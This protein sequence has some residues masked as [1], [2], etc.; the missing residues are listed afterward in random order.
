MLVSVAIAMGFSYPSIALQE[1]ASSGLSALAHQVWT[2]AKPIE[3]G[4]LAVDV[5][6]RQVW[7]HGSYMK[8]LEKDVLKQ[9]LRI[10]RS[11]VHDDFL[12]PLN[13]GYH[14]PLMYWNS[15]EQSIDDDQ[16]IL[17]TINERRHAMSSLDVVL[18]PATVLA[19]KKFDKDE[20]VGADALVITLMNKLGDEAGAEWQVELKMLRESVCEHCIIYPD[21]GEITNDK[22]YE[23]SLT[24][25]SLREHSALALAY[26]FMAL[27]VLLSLRRM[28]AFHSRF[29][30]V[31]TAITQMTCSILAS[32]TICDILKINLST[33]PQ[34]AYPFVVL[35]FGVENMFRLI[36]AVLAY[37]PT[38][39]TEMRIAQALGD[40]G[41]ISVAAAAQNLTILSILSTV[42][43][44]GVAAFCAFA[45]I[46][47]LFDAFFL[48]TFFVAVLNVDIHRLE[49]QDALAA[50][51][52]QSRP[53]HRR[54]PSPTS[55]TWF[56]A[57][58]HGRLP[59]S[60][61]MAGTIVT[62]TFILSL[63]YHFSEHHEQG[64][65]LRQ[66]LGLERGAS[67]GVSDV[68]PFAAPLMN[69]TSSPADW[70][71][72]QDLDTARELIKLAKP[73][74]SSL[75]VRV[76]A[77][78]MIVLDG[79][80]RSGASTVDEPWTHAL[81]SFAIHYFYPV[82]VAVVF[83]VA[84]VFVLM[85]FLL[86]S[87]A[88][89]EDNYVALEHLEDHFTVTNVALPHSLDVVKMRSCE[90]GHFVTIGLDRTIAITV[91]DRAQ[92]THRTIAVPAEV[93]SNIHWPVRHL[94]IDDT[95][96]RIACHCAD[97]R[98]LTFNAATGSFVSPVMQYP[99][100]HPALIFNFV[101]LP[102]TGGTKLHLV[103]LTSAG[104]LT[105]CCMDDGTSGGVDLTTT[106]L[107]GAT[108]AE[109]SSLGRQLYVAKEDG[110]I[111][112]FAW[113]SGKWVQSSVCAPEAN[114]QPQYSGGP[115]DLQLYNDFDIEYLIVTTSSSVSFL[116]SGTLS[117]VAR[118]N[119]IDSD[120]STRRVLPGSAQ[121][122]HACRGP[123]LLSIIVSSE[124][125]NRDDCILTTWTAGDEPDDSICLTQNSS[126]CRSLATA[127]KEQHKLADLGAWAMTKP[128]GIIGLR[129]RRHENGH[130]DSNASI[131][132]RRSTTSHVRQ[133]RSNASVS[134]QRERK[135]DEAWEVYQF[136]PNG[137]IETL[138]LPTSTGIDGEDT[139]LFV[140]NP[141]PIVS[142]DSQAVAVGFGN[143][144]KVIRIAKARAASRRATGEGLDRG[145]GVE[146][147]VN[148][149]VRRTR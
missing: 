97:D 10:Q 86:Y 68:E 101:P 95:G 89:D 123:G 143:T 96:E 126:D 133:R 30:L 21:N 38:M 58:V 74:A 93:T 22:I 141:G 90:S 47:T 107:V 20:L 122:C 56:D 36:N 135:Q 144:V 102:V 33:I 3:D 2:T 55:D 80:D 59:F 32:F 51:H 131:T 27:Y 103:S 136:S 16:D 18:R 118:L 82:A 48:L 100:D 67:T 92:L 139:A 12:T 8:A 61:R 24:P 106:A 50:R 142:L 63:N 81:R 112:S 34:N 65:N 84:F 26:G 77:P 6:M 149:S 40:I 13:W 78:L 4:Q 88:E 19:G 37:P 83:I 52:G 115:I 53:R 125:A 140:S 94:A 85:N 23:L 17:K 14:S 45:A 124:T 109:S 66:L 145:N 147:R 130:S 54:R 60:T 128:H 28:K 49:L 57:L 91:M 79:S 138:D 41:P 146:R 71:R 104:R 70:I 76:W 119:I 7:V 99:D 29:G 44:P 127:R 108:I 113:T 11:L 111:V 116:N 64:T 42:V 105:M 69:V 120:T 39:A 35:V 62:T 137:D 73:G 87:Q 25:L 15:S 43:S 134:T 129:R 1:N 98:V 9:A 72:S 110:G 148:G 31:V 46:A 132:A 5:E 114:S 117:R 75:V 121:S